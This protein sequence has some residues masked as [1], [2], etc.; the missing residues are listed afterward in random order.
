MVFQIHCTVE[1]NYEEEDA[2]LDYPGDDDEDCRSALARGIMVK[3][4]DERVDVLLPKILTA[5]QTPPPNLATQKLFKLP[6][7][8]ARKRHAIM[9]TREGPGLRF[10]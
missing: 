9:M 7:S 1:Q 5:L 6:A 2:D 4:P 3:I 10:Q 8:M